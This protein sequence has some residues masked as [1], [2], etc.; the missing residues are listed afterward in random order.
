[1]TARAVWPSQDTHPALH[2]FLPEAATTAVCLRPRRLSNPRTAVDA[3]DAGRRAC[4]LAR[5]AARL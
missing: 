3:V 2:R 1:M 4:H 5:A